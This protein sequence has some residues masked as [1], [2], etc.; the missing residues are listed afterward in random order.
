[1]VKV[2]LLLNLAFFRLWSSFLGRER[3][4]FQIR[5]PNASRKN[6]V[7]LQRVYD[8]ASAV[9]AKIKDELQEVTREREP[10]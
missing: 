8:S 1:M 10:Q 7:I 4:I 9:C 2:D 3:K 5:A 6:Q